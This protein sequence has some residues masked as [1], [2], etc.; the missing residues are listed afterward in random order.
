MF[1]SK[2]DFAAAMLEGRKFIQPGTNEIIQFNSGFINPFRCG[3]STL[4]GGWD[5]WKI[6]EEYFEPFKPE[7]GDMIVVSDF[8]TFKISYKRKFVVKVNG[9][10]ICMLEEKQNL[11]DPD[12]QCMYAWKYAK[13]VN[14]K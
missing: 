12:H 6:V 10:Y 3:D 13:E 2:K 5:V 1:N 7:I 14:K 4:S 9:R 11:T 8:S